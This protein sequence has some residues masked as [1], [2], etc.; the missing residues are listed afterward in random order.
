M[1]GGGVDG[2]LDEQAADSNELRDDPLHGISSKPLASR[3]LVLIEVRSGSVSDASVVVSCSSCCCCCCWISALR[4]SLHNTSNSDPSFA[5]STLVES[6]VDVAS[7]TMSPVVVTTLDVVVVS[8][9]SDLVLLADLPSAVR[10]ISTTGRCALIPASCRAVDPVVFCASILA[11]LARSISTTL[12]CPPS[13]ASMSAVAPKLVFFT[14][15]SAPAARRV[16]TTLASPQPLASMSAVAP[17]VLFV[18][19]TSAPALSSISTTFE[20]P[21]SLAIMSAV[22]PM[23]VW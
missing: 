20:N 14:S 5:S 13:L 12:Q 3:Q 17:K 16:S 15:V 18:V 22:T 10:S 21:L 1:G 4:A 23:E 8:V 7:G 11:P 2:C 6:H 19:S 9:V